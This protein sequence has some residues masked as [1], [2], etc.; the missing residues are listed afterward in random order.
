MVW[1]EDA[2][3]CKKT[4]RLWHHL[5]C[6]LVHAAVSG[7]DY[8]EHKKTKKVHRY[9]CRGCTQLWSQSKPGGRF[10][11]IYDGTTVIQLILNEPPQ[12]L[13]HTHL[14]ARTRYF[15][16]FEPRAEL[17]DTIPILPKRNASVRIKATDPALSDQIW[18]TVLGDQDGCDAVVAIEALA[19]AAFEENKGS[20]KDA[21]FLDTANAA[22]CAKQNGGS[23]KIAAGSAGDFIMVNTED[24]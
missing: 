13:L 3:Y 21:V 11:V 4:N 19:K 7:F 22:R 17:R 14:L 10:L 18:Q 12:K 8:N 16:K 15:K 9:K 1:V 2:D 23:I 24:L 20:D 6:G 5:E